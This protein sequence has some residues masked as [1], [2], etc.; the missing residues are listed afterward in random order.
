MEI[1]ATWRDDPEVV[2]SHRLPRRLSQLIVGLWLY[3]ASMALMIESGL[4][5]DPWDV[6]HQGVSLHSGLSFGSVTA[7]VGALALLFWLPLR[8]RPGVGT[9]MNIVVIA[10]SVDGALRWLPAAGDGPAAI[11]MLVAGVVGNAL[12]G[13]MYVGADLGPGPRDGLWVA[14]VRRSGL[15][16]RLVRTS[17]ELT[18]VAVGFTLGGTVGVGTVVYALAI[19]PL[20]QAFLPRVRVEAPAARADAAAQAETAAAKPTAQADLA[21][22]AAPIAPEGSAGLT[23]SAGQEASARSAEPMRA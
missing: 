13:A 5:V 19:G 21:A 4:G 6:F 11:A 7:L 14:I 16:V 10:I 15:S 8:Q 12:G 3:G 9:I 2:S 1:A 22:Q 17:M 18:V 20:V 23:G